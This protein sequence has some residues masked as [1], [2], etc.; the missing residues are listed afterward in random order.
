MFKNNKLASSV[1]LA[2]AFG[3]ALSAGNLAYAQEAE[4][5]NAADEAAVEKITVTGSR[6][7]RDSSDT[8]Q[9]TEI[10]SDRI[11]IRQFTNTIEALQELPFVGP[12]SDATGDNDQYGSNQANVDLL[13]LGSNR[14]LT[15]V[16]GQ[17]FVSSNQ[18]TVF[19]PGN[20]NGSQVDLSLINPSLIENV[21]TI[22]GSGGS[23]TYGADAV[24]GVVNIILK[25]DYEGVEA[26]T[27]YGTTDRG[28]GENFRF[29]LLAGDN[30]MDGRLNITGSFEYFKSDL[31]V[32]NDPS[33][34]SGQQAVAFANPANNGND[35]GLPSVLWQNGTHNPLTSFGGVLMGGQRIGNSS[36]DFFYP[37]RASQNDLLA[38]R[39]KAFTDAGLGTPWEYGQTAAG[40]AID[41]N[42]F[43]G[44]FTD[45]TY[46]TVPNTDPATA[47]ILP[48]RAVPL[49]FNQA[50]QLVPFDVGNIQP[51]RL[52][53]MNSARGGDG[54]PIGVFDNLRSEQER[55]TV[56]LLTRFDVTDNIVYKG[57]V[58]FSEM[59]DNSTDAPLSNTSAGASSAGSFSLPV[60]IDQNPFFGQE[61]LA[62]IDGLV[63]QGLDVPSINGDR[64]L[65]LNRTY[66]D[67]F[68]GPANSGG[69]TQF[70][71]TSHSLAGDLFLGDRFFYWEVNG[72]YGRVKRTNYSDQLFDIEFALATDVVMQNGQE[73][74]RQQT[75]AEPEAI[76]VRNPGLSG[77]NSAVGLTPTA[78]QVAACQPLNLFGE[79]APSQAA[80][81]YVTTNSGSENVSEQM[82]FGT[83][84]GGDIY[85][86]PGGTAVF[87]VSAEFRRE[88]NE[89]TPDNTFGLGLARNTTGQGSN[90]ES[91]FIEYGVEVS[92]PVFGN[93]FTFMGL[94]SL[95]IDGAYRVVD[96]SSEG[97]FLNLK[98]D[99]KDE[100]YNI[101]AR[102]SPYEGVT[103]RG[104]TSKAVRSPSIVELFGAGIQGFASIGRGNLNPCD[105]DRIDSGPAV[106]RTNCEALAEAVGLD[107][108]YLDGFQSTGG[109]APASGS[110]NA[111][112]E[113]EVSD[114][115]SVGVVLQPSAIEGL[116]VSFDY[117]EFELEGELSLAA[118]I[119]DC[120][121]SD[122]YPN[123]VVGGFNACEALVYPTQ[124]EQGQWIVPFNNPIT[125]TPLPEV[126]RPGSLAQTQEGM[127]S[128]YAF[129]PTLNTGNSTLRSWNLSTNYGFDAG[130]YGSFNIKAQ[131]YRLLE[132]TERGFP[133]EGEFEDPK[134]SG[135][136]SLQ[137]TYE[138]FS[139]LVQ[140]FHSSSTVQN[141]QNEVP[142]VELDPADVRPSFNRVNYSA[143][144]DVNDNVRLSA[145]VNNVFDRTEDEAGYVMGDV[146]GRRFTVGVTTRF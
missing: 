13:N 101:G 26:K 68:G 70:F 56:N 86:L 22:I 34:L 106:R 61:N 112:L 38:K 47:A 129:Y 23:A 67:I 18:A 4:N 138:N 80:I 120:F 10:G 89:F 14:T 20:A 53:D 83:N 51:S 98:S 96:R 103:F 66:R 100:V 17:R 93:D 90:G 49:Q 143:F 97:G 63:A 9:V 41:P 131:V 144:Y 126:A 46:L 5:D 11:E 78:E 134:W 87:N 71:R 137:H 77:I 7:R 139:H 142:A 146:L 132:Y 54:V 81:D 12:G 30:Y 92:V 115:W 73:V 110:S 72:S 136:I 60:F 50:G 21:E 79:G 128:T 15:L 108:S 117:Y 16:N 62:I 119:Y 95:V 122:T 113:N 91:D 33:R 2:C 52:G 127:T 82:Y 107:A 37:F 114:S 94:E 69:E 32:D 116:T 124:N 85:E 19:V 75:L 140:F 88:T 135:N 55:I 65:Y 57:D 58:I 31:V 109:S 43:I 40:R 118:L 105:A 44:T 3:M 39:F 6:L 24:A 104:N 121:D 36:A 145:V 25:D 74:C 28:D 45:G 76:D 59:D 141:V 130:E 8:I 35:D 111:G 27:Q 133:N 48:R 99:A 29:N 102:W 64:A 1:K 123:A 42:L 125:G 84:F